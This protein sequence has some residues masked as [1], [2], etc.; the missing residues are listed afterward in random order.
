MAAT[1]NLSLNAAEKSYIFLEASTGGYYGIFQGANVP[2]AG[3]VTMTPTSIIEDLKGTTNVS[4]VG[5]TKT[6][7]QLVTA[8][9]EP[10]AALLGALGALG[11]LRRRRF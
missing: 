1:G 3:A 9:P 7:W 8:V 6:G 11:L 2:A 5:A 10:T 4:T